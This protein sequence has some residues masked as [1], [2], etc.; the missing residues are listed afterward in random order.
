[1][2]KNIQRHEDRI[3]ANEASQCGCRVVTDGFLSPPTES[4]KGDAKENNSGTPGASLLVER[5]EKASIIEKEEK[6]VQLDVAFSETPRSAASQAFDSFTTVSPNSTYQ[7]TPDVHSRLVLE[8]KRCKDANKER[9]ESNPTSTPFLAVCHT[10]PTPSITF[11]SRS[12]FS[13]GE[14]LA[15]WYT[16]DPNGYGMSVFMV[17]IS[18]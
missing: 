12:P 5:E 15:N 1:M 13:P 9:M 8:E 7:D 18:V 6:E 3:V 17:F 11:V 4:S 10:Q 16:L 14:S 2:Q